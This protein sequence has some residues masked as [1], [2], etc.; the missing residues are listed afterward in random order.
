MQNDLETIHQR[1]RGQWA[2]CGHCTFWRYHRL[3]SF[4]QTYLPL[5]SYRGRRRRRI[6][7]QLLQRDLTM[8]TMKLIQ[9]REGRVTTMGLKV[10]MLYSLMH[11]KFSIHRPE[12]THLLHKGKYLCTADILFDW[13]GFSCFGIP[14]LIE[15]CKFGWIQTSQIGG[16]PYGYTS[17]Y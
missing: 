5:R 6:R 17:P 14:N 16:H 13:L 8:N 2:H 12:N 11:Q 7:Q 3:A 1:L 15:I 10:L 4:C 9:S